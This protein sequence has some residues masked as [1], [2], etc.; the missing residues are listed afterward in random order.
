MVMFK[1]RFQS[2]LY[3]HGRVLR[4]AFRPCYKF[5]VVFKTRFRTTAIRP[6]SCLTLALTPCYIS[7]RSCLKL[8]FRRPCYMLT[9]I[10]YTCF[11]T[12]VMLFPDLAICS[13][14]YF[15]NLAIC[16]RL[17]RKLVSRPCYML[18]VEMQHL[19]VVT[20]GNIFTIAV[21]NLIKFIHDACNVM[22]DYYTLSCF[23]TLSFKFGNKA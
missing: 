14:T 19:R 10:L 8:A 15:L 2:L 23:P 20:K 16:S 1:T 22:L 17:C 11:Q 21:S 5:T 4:L 18:T 9:V 3:A 6:R 7:S 12:F 13:Y